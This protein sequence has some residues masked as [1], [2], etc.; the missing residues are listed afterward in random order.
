MLVGAGGG[1]KRAALPH[2]C[3]GRGREEDRGGLL[4]C[5]LGREEDGT[6]LLSLMLAQGWEEDG[7][8]LLSLVLA[9]GRVRARCESP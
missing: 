6:G 4:A 8:G 2:A 7:R 9:Q 3:W 5:L 1:Q